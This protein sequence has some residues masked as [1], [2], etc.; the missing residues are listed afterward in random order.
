MIRAVHLELVDSLS[1][2]DF[3][4]DLKRFEA[5]RGMPSVI[6]S[7]NSKT[8]HASDNFLRKKVGKPLIWKFSAPLAPWWGRWWERLIRLVKSA[9][10]K[11]LGKSL[12]TRSQLETVLH[13]IEACINS[14]PLTY[15]GETRNPL[16]PSHF[17]LGRS[18]PMRGIF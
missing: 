15:V 7:D 4:L 6:Y 3:I 12:V 1:V 14:R 18:T 8:F 11:S 17:L 13:E 16:T 5:R 9:L 10:K 2:E